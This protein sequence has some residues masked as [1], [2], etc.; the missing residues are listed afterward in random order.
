MRKKQKHKEHPAK[1]D[2]KYGSIIVGKLINKVMRNGEKRIATRIVYQAAEIIEKWFKENQEKKKKEPPIVKETTETRKTE[3]KIS[4]ELKE[5]ELTESINKDNQ[6][7][8]LLKISSPFLTVLEEA[9]A[10]VKPEI[11]MKSIKRGAAN[12]RV[13]KVINETR[14]LKIV[15]R[16]LVE[17][18]KE[19]LVRKPKEKKVAKTMFESLAEEIKQAYHKSGETFKKKE[20]LY[21]AAEAGKVFARTSNR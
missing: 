19:K 10:N 5:V 1:P 14:S 16:W 9:L 21:K 13:P 18:A 15:L 4:K 7:K 2:G 11:E 17:S 12:Y 3:K 20:T 6:E 8:E